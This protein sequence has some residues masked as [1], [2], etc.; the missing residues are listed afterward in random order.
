MN[1]ND[2]RG[3]TVHFQFYRAGD[4]WYKLDDFEFPVPV[5]DLNNATLNA[6]EK[7]IMLMRWMRKH[8]QFLEDAKAFDSVSIHKDSNQ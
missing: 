8:E 3:K 5:S 4:L 1:A 6:E 2:I 7:A